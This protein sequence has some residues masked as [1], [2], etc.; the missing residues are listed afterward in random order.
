M[1]AIVTS[2]TQQVADVNPELP[3]DSLVIAKKMITDDE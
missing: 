2:S 1:A 3:K